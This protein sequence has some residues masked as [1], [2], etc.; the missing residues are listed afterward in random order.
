MYAIRSYYETKAER[1]E[2][3]KREKDGLA[4]IADIYRY[5]RTKEEIDPEDIDRFKWYGLYTQNR[6][7]QNED[8]P[9]QYYMLRIKLEGGRLSP[10]QAS[11]LGQISIDYARGS[12]DL[13][14]R[15][16]NNFV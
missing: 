16:R 3:I 12:A 9:T 13:T 6:T 8:D 7:L 2:R 14:T 1:I 11:V 10:E 15:Q 4:V 5:A